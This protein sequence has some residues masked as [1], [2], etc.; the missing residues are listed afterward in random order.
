MGVGFSA[1]L[2]ATPITG[3]LYL[4][5]W[6]F[7]IYRKPKESN[8]LPRIFR[9]AKELTLILAL[10]VG[11]YA[12]VIF[13]SFR[14][15]G[16]Y[17]KYPGTGDFWR[18]PLKYP[19]QLEMIDGLERA[20]ISKWDPSTSVIPSIA[21]GISSCGISGDYFIGQTGSSY[22]LFNMMNEELDSVEG[23]DSFKAELQKRN[24]VNP[25]LKTIREFYDEYWKTH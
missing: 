21:S 13:L 4:F 5:L 12:G 20:H 22:I 1:I 10:F 23:L 19:Y 9:G 16:S 8:A 25:K 6:L 14:N 15:S 3:T 7:R 11:S 17:E 18:V 2:W 24:I